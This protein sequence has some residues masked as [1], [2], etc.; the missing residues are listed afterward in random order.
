MAKQQQ[1]GDV[2][3][4]V[5]GMLADLSHKLQY[6]NIT[7]YQ[8][9]CFLKKQNP[10]PG[11]F[12]DRY[13]VLQVSVNRDQSI[14]DAV[15]AGRYDWACEDINE[16]Y[17]TRT[18][19]GSEDIEIILV[20]FDKSMTFNDVVEELEKR[21]L[22]PVDIQELLAIGEQHPGKQRMFPIV[23]LG[24]IWEDSEEDQ[25]IQSL[26]CSGNRRELIRFWVG[27]KASSWFRFAAVRK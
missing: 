9:E 7:P 21:G 25:Y 6:G 4:N 13:E 22:R 2:P 26:D 20:C 1:I 19:S 18:G 15:S 24:S 23:A 11:M 3:G 14:A 27:N 16:N 10:F 5:L 8:L 12:T 17:F